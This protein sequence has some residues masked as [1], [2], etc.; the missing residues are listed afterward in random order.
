MKRSSS[1][2]DKLK[3][4]KIESH[5]N[6]QSSK[7]VPFD[8]IIG[9]AHVK[10][11]RNISLFVFCVTDPVHTF[12]SEQDIISD[13]TARNESALIRVNDF[14][15]NSSKP[16]GDGPDHHLITLHRLMGR[17]FSIE[18]GSLVFGIRVMTMGFQLLRVS[19]SLRIL[20]MDEDMSS[21]MVSQTF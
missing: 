20:R 16:I 15:K 10:F 1:L 7:I 3:P 14:T 2:Q 9:F 21:P 4:S 19:P 5:F 17:N 11:K 13:K 18:L 12:V 6:H 8:V